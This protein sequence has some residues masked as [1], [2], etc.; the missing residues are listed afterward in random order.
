MKT[1]L[2]GR[3]SFG[4][5]DVLTANDMTLMV[6]GLRDWDR[7]PPC[8]EQ[9]QVDGVVLRGTVPIEPF[10]PMLRATPCVTVFETPQ[11]PSIGDQVLED[12]DSVGA[13]AVATLL[14]RGA[15]RL[16]YLDRDAL[17]P[18]YAA[19]RA[20]FLK[21][22]QQA[23]VEVDVIN[24]AAPYGELVERFTLLSP[25][26]DGLFVPSPDD[27]VTQIYTEFKQRG[28]VLGTDLL[29]ISCSYDP[30]RLASLDPRLSY[31]D[32]RPEVI[33]QAAAEMLLWR[34][35]H[36]AEPQRRLL[37]APLLVEPELKILTQ[38]GDGA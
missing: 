10:L 8:I 12:N 34:L 32:I 24:F 38:R 17:H 23:G 4:I 20:G 28:I 2:S 3:L 1:V 6:S 33:G 26:P 21:A 25:A 14:K 9:S 18:A 16:A 5:S 15:R 27:Q 35:K 30:G 13:L 29:F 22:A 19:R 36:P 37:I 7:M 31:I 11:V